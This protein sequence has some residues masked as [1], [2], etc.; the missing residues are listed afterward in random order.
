MGLADCLDL[1]AYKT[2]F[3]FAC[4]CGF[5]DVVYVVL[6]VMCAVLLV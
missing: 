2:R 6:W 5:V 1:I 4:A 3:V